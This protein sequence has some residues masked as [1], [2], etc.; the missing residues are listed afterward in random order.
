MFREVFVIILI[1][2]AIGTLMPLLERACMTLNLWT[3]QRPSALSPGWFLGVYKFYFLHLIVAVIPGF[4][5]R[6]WMGKRW[7]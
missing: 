6:G 3:W 4:F 1:L 5:V 7:T 2:G